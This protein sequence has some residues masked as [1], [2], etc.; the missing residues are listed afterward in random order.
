MFIDVVPS[1]VVTQSKYIDATETKQ[2]QRPTTRVGTQ[3]SSPFSIN[4]GVLKAHLVICWLTGR[5]IQM[6]LVLL[7]Y[8]D[9]VQ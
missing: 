5:S 6:P 4:N 2:K 8:L 7:S 1:N 9:E 3:F